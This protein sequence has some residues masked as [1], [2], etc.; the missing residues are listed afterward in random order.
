MF[1]HVKR[2]LLEAQLQTR[3]KV[4]FAVRQRRTLLT[5]RTKRF[6]KRVREDAA[7]HRRAMVPHH[8]DA[9]RVMAKVIQVQTKLPALFGADDL[10]KLIDEPWPAVRR[11]AH[12]LALIAVMRKAE[13]LR[14]RGVDDAGRV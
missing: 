13:K 14:R 8:L 4:A 2:D 5:R 10:A 9:F 7:N 1:E 12:H 3:R 11:K 6:H